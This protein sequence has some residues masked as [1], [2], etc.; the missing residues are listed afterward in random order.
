[1]SGRRHCRGAGLH[2]LLRS[3]DLVQMAAWPQTVNVLGAIKTTRNHAAMDPVGHV[4]ALYAANMRGR[5]VPLDLP[6]GVPLDAVAAVGGAHTTLT[7]G[8][9]N[10]SPRQAVGLELKLPGMAGVSSSIWRINGAGLGDINIP[11][12]P[13]AVTVTSLGGAWSPDQPLTLPA[14]S[15]TVVQLK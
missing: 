5:L 15:V 1:M 10:Y 12:N 13:E 4:F 8:L 11:G 3:A 6:N 14:H 9:I 7:I 2:E